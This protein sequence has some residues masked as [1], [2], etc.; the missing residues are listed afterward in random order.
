MARKRPGRWIEYLGDEGKWAVEAR[1]G[2]V[3]VRIMMRCAAAC[4]S[5]NWSLVTNG[6]HAC[7]ATIKLKL[8]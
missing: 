6:T 8:I 1:A 3:R 4:L 5:H 2:K 7:S